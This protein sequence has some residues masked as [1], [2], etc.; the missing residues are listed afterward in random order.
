ML[1]TLNIYTKV[2]HFI[3]LLNHKYFTLRIFIMKN[4]SYCDKKMLR[5]NMKRHL[6]TCEIK[7]TFGTP[8]SEIIDSINLRRNSQTLQII[9]LKYERVSK[10]LEK[11]H[12]EINEIIQMQREIDHDKKIEELIISEGT[13]L[14]YKADW[15]M[16]FNWCKLKSVD[17]YL[18]SSANHYL[19]QLKN[20]ISTIKNKR[21]RLQSMLRFFL[22]SSV[23]L[24]PIRRRISF[25]PK[26]TL[27]NE[28]L[29]EY[30]KEQK[31]I[32]EEDFLIQFILSVYGC[33][34]NSVAC[35]QKKHLLF[36]QNGDKM[37]L[38]DSKT[39]SREVNVSKELK[40]KLSLY[41]EENEIDDEDDFLFTASSSDSRKRSI[42]ICRRINL[43]IKSSKVLKHRD[44]HAFSTHMFRKS[45]AFNM[46]DRL[47]E[48]AKEKVRKEIGHTEKSRSVEHYIYK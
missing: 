47:V 18:N 43:R 19:S 22:N 45:K 34:I 44:T 42:Q 36:L 8:Y 10:F 48:E 9:Q 27:S 5:Q 30:L 46:Y 13:K 4:C 29:F 31:E 16:Y 40:E 1:Y 7:N 25:K 12:R 39:G 41:V 6:S 14:Q 32:N 38:P 37:I 33:R 2:S 24:R 23:S 17:P 3:I 15:N 26:Y 21:N 35:L 28:E 20:K 11:T